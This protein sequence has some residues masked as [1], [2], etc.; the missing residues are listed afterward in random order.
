MRGQEH[1]KSPLPVR[2]SR[3]TFLLAVAALLVAS[4]IGG[5]CARGRGGADPSGQLVAGASN[6]HPCLLM[7]CGFMGT[8]IAIERA[9]AIKERF[10]FAAPGMS[11]LAGVLMLAGFRRPPTTL[12]LWPRW[13]SLR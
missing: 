5:F 7:I 9:V 1:P 11:G 4:V 13:S 10:A 2:V 3:V 12:R 6:P 8:V